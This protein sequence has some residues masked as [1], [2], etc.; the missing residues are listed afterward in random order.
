M[1]GGGIGTEFFFGGGVCRGVALWSGNG[2]GL[3]FAGKN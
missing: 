2:E 3:F 1:P